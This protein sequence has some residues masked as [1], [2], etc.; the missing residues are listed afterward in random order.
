MIF[1]GFAQELKK[2]VDIDWATIALIDGDELYFMALSS[3]IG[4]AW[5][6]EERIPLKETATEWVCREKR[7][8]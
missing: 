1:E 5:Q 6:T 3:T 4:S 2:V 7:S 8:L